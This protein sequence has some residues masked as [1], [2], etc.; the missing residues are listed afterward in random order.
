[1]LL[2]PQLIL[3]EQRLRQD[4]G[5]QV[6]GQW[7]MVLEHACIVGGRFGGGGSVQLAADILDLLGDVAGASPG[8]ALERHV[9]EKMGDPVLVFRLVAGTRLDPDAEGD[10]LQMGHGLGYYRQP[11]CEPGHL[12]IHRL[13]FR[14]RRHS[15]ACSGMVADEFFD[16]LDLRRQ[17]VEALLPVHEIGEP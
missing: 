8:R 15:L 7:H 12:Y 1:V 3:V 16:G 6:Y 4:V 14:R 10:A 11:G 9:L 2:P 13:S 17:D 5:Q